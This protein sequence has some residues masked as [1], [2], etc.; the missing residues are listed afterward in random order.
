MSR[1]ASVLVRLGVVLGWS[2]ESLIAKEDMA[3]TESVFEEEEEDGVGWQTW[4][5]VRSGKR[6]EEIEAEEEHDNLSRLGNRF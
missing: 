3:E 2:A 4:H 6:T 5:M 1:Q